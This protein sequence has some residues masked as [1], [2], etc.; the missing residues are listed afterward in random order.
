MDRVELIHQI[1]EVCPLPEVARNVMRL[2]ADPDVSMKDVVMAIE[3]DPGIAA[4]I[5]RHANSPVYRRANPARNLRE[6][7]LRLGLREVHDLTMAMAMLAAFHSSAE[8]E[9]GLQELSVLAGNYGRSLGSEL[10]RDPGEAYLAALMTE[11]GALAIC[12]VDPDYVPLRKASEQLADLEIAEQERYG[13]TS[14]ALGAELMASNG[15]PEDIVA[16][17]GGTGE[18]EDFKALVKFARA[19]ARAIVVAGQT[20][21]IVELVEELTMLGEL[22]PLEVDPSRL[23]DLALE[24]SADASGALTA[25]IAS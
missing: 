18:D 5:V 12:A 14:R 19:A 9:L 2:A 17:V 23:V 8:R 6:A 15:F 4:E 20:G 13:T 22:S 25:A 11:L 21:Q 1:K 3:A 10:G 7:T 16:A 24:A